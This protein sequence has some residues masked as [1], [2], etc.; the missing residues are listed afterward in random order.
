MDYGDQAHIMKDVEAKSKSNLSTMILYSV[1]LSECRMCFVARG[2]QVWALY[3][4]TR[5]RVYEFVLSNVFTEISIELLTS[6]D[7]A[8]CQLDLGHFQ[9]DRRTGYEGFEVQE[10]WIRGRE[11]ALI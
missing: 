1:L 9:C 10:R 8:H 4:Q 6:G 5:V 11:W 2:N 7:P 3:D